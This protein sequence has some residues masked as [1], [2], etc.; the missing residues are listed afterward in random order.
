MAVIV[1]EKVKGSNEWWIFI[2]HNGKRRSK[3]IGSKKAANSVK[4][5]IEARLA[6]G[7]MGMIKEKP[8]TLSKY[9]KEIFESPLNGW[10]KGTAYE[11]LCTFKRHIK[12][13]FG[14]KRLD[15]IKRKHVKKM[16]MPR[17]FCK[18]Y[19]IRQ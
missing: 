19:C 10:A 2:N 16:I 6:R 12:P 15:E 9:G 11:Y 14:R 18:R 3:K 8:P 13:R 17:F 1:R 7:D 5:E 4:R